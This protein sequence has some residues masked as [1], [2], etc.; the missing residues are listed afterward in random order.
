MT[1]FRDEVVAMA[2]MRGIYL[3]DRGGV[4]L[5]VATSHPALVAVLPEAWSTHAR[6]A[7]IALAAQ[8][9]KS[10]PSASAAATRLR[11]LLPSMATPFISSPNASSAAWSSP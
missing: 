9:S 7:W 5:S 3:D 8:S 2:A 6:G 11:I 4:G 10:N 1:I